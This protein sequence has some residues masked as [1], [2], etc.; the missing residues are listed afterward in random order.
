LIDVEGEGERIKNA[1]QISTP[2]NQ[3]DMEM[4]ASIDFKILFYF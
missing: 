2:V 3:L 4:R 1:T